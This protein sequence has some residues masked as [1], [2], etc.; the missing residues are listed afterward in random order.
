MMRKAV[1]RIGAVALFFSALVGIGST[2]DAFSHKVGPGRETVTARGIAVKVHTYRP[3]DCTEPALLFVF[4]GNSR[5]ASSYLDHARPLA[6]R[7]CLLVFAPLFDEERFPNATYHR[8]GVVDDDGVLPRAD[9]TVDIVAELVS[10]ARRRE[11]RPDAPYYLFGHSAGGQF[12]SRVAAFAPPPDAKRIVIAN[13]STHV[14]ASLDEA[15]PYGFG[16]VFGPEEAAQL[17]TYLALPVTI[18]LGTEDIEDEDLTDTDAAR[19]QGT[20]R[21]ERGRAAFASAR[22]T[23]LRNG[24]PFGWRLVEAEGVGHSARDMLKSDRVED[25]FGLRVPA[26]AE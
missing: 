17:R 14:L 23:A 21:L 3:S 7:E 20:N 10:W 8:G 15:A 13:P 25:A 11:G 2:P 6:D 9:W 5:S 1:Y 19:R 16:G 22:D 12:L 4:H 24:W 26:P 18:F